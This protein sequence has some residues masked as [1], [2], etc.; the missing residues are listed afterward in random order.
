M[1]TKSLPKCPTCDGQRRV[2]RRR[3]STLYACGFISE[4]HQ[5]A[6]CNGTGL[7][8]FN[9]LLGFLFP[10]LRENDLARR[11]LESVIRGAR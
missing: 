6:A 10:R 4:A 2:I 1:P 11:R 8:P 9:R 5:C 3:P 7:K